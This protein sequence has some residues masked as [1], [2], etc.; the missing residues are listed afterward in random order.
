LAEEI[1]TESDNFGS[2]PAR[3]IMEQAARSW[4]RLAEELEHRLSKKIALGSSAFFG[5][6]GIAQRPSGAV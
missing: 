1:R 2:L 5:M 6:P 3:E 4:D